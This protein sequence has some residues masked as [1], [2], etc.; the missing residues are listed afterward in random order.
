LARLRWIFIV[1]RWA[2]LI[3]LIFSALLV[4]FSLNFNHL[5]AVLGG[6]N[7]NELHLPAQLLPLL[8]GAF[9]FLRICWLTFEEWRSPGDRDP[10]VSQSSNEPRESRTMHLGLGLLAFSPAMSRDARAEAEH[11]DDELDEFEKKRSRAVRYLVSWLP[12]LSLLRHMRNEDTNTR[13]ETPILPRE[14]QSDEAS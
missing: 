3:W 8:V 10:S 6:P 1:M 9:G 13:G 14:K 7:D 2:N 12:W 11:E 5:N 4:E